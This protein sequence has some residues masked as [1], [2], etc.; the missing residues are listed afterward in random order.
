MIYRNPNGKVYNIVDNSS[1]YDDVSCLCLLQT[2]LDPR[3][4][5]GIVIENFKK[6]YE[7]FWT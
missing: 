2:N 3:K 5:C 6:E 1:V 4:T 7:G